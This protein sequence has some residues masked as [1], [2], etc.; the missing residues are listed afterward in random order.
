[1]D[2]LDTS[3][4]DQ[5]NLFVL[6]VRTQDIPTIKT[7]DPGAKLYDTILGRISSINGVRLRDYLATKDQESEEFTREFNITSQSLDNSPIVKGKPPQEG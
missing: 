2:R 4:I 3:A 5:P 7:L 6:N 1:M